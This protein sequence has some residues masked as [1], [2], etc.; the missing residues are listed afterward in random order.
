LVDVGQAD[1]VTDQLTR[2]SHCAGLSGARA[3]NNKAAA[4]ELYN[5]LR[6]G[7]ARLGSLSRANE[8]AFEIRNTRLGLR[9]LRLGSLSRTNELG[10]EIRNTL[11]GLFPGPRCLVALVLDDE[12]L[13]QPAFASRS[14]IVIA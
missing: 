1:Y 5:T 12:L 4:F 8:F 9:L 2:I 13:C 10:F 14:A 6:I 11:F 3:R 7:F